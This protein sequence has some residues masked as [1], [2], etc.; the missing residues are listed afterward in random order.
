MNKNKLFGKLYLDSERFHSPS[1]IIRLHYTT[2]I[3][4]N[5]EY[6]IIKWRKLISL[7]FGAQSQVS[8]RRNR[9]Q[10]VVLCPFSVCSES[11][12]L[13]QDRRRNVDLLFSPPTLPLP[14]A[15]ARPG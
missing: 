10:I 14:A 11:D 8:I 13:W 2:Y 15:V 5:F 1:C 6:N 7:H 12:F 3:Y 4:V 9:A